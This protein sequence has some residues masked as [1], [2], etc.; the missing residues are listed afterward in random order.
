MLSNLLA[1]SRSKNDSTNTPLFFFL[2][3]ITVLWTLTIVTRQQFHLVL[4]RSLQNTNT[5]NLRVKSSQPMTVVPQIM[6]GTCDVSITN[7]QTL[8]YPPSEWSETGGYTVFTVVFLS[9]C[10][11]TLS[12]I[13][14][15]GRNDVLFA[16]NVFDLCMK[17]WEYFRMDNI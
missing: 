7:I 4:L 6:F 10:L 5:H 8:L 2:L 16:I 9:V 15:N 17:S 14:L 3:R 1:M 13:G 11:C 12:P